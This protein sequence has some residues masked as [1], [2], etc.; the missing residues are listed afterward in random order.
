MLGLEEGVG[1]IKMNEICF[2]VFEGFVS[3]EG[4]LI[5]KNINWDIGR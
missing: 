1:D 3:K 2:F 5:V 4:K